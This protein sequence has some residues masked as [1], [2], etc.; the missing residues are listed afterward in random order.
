MKSS[1]YL[2]FHSLS[3]ISFYGSWASKTLF[4]Q[5][6]LLDPGF[7]FPNNQFMSDT[8]QTE[9]APPDDH[10][11]WAAILGFVGLVLGLC[12]SLVTC[13]FT[14]GFF[15]SAQ[16]SI[17]DVSY[18]LASSGSLIEITY[19]YPVGTKEYTSKD[20]VPARFHREFW[21]GRKIPV[22]YSLISPNLTSLRPPPPP[23]PLFLVFG[24]MALVGAFSISYRRSGDK[25][26]RF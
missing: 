1:E 17:K 3:F 26:N 24:S 23:S 16:G 15:G 21:V 6:L 18:H 2:G 4:P 22:H 13:Y 8:S 25:S 11:R 19:A 10:I 5:D 12:G 7:S 14:S 9:K 20:A